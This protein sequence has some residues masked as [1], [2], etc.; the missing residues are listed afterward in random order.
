MTKAAGLW[1]N[2]TGMAGK[3]FDLWHTVHL[4]VFFLG[5]TKDISDVGDMDKGTKKKK[6]HKR[7]RNDK[8]GRWILYDD[9]YDRV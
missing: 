7:R 5:V 2:V 6:K 8:I 3:M 9:C 4:G 1:M